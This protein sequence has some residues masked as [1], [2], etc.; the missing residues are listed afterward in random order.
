[1]ST[2][3]TSKH[4]ELVAE[5]FI[6]TDAA[7]LDQIRKDLSQD[8]IRFMSRMLKEQQIHAGGASMLDRLKKS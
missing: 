2:P 8:Y 5:D 7:V 6:E 4:P 3:A 1:M